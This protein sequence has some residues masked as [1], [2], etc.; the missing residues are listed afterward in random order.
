MKNSTARK[1]RQ[2][3]AGFL[4]VGVDPHKKKHAAAAMT[5]DAVIRCK[6][7]VV[8]SRR[9]YE[10]L[11]ERTRAQMLVT[12]SRGVIFA[13]E[14][15]SHFWRNLAYYLEAHGIPFRLI[16]PFTLK[17]RREGRDLNRV[18]NDFRDAQMA[19]ELLRTGDF[20]QTKLPQGVY[21]ELRAAYNAYRRLVKDRAR[22]LNLLKGLLDGVFPEFDQ[23]F[24]DP[25]GKTA[26]AVLSLCPVPGVIAGMREE[27]YV[28][29]VK[30]GHGG[31]RLKLRKLRALHQ[32]ACTS[33]GI[34]LGKQSISVELC[35]LA[36]RLRINAE[37]V[38]KMEG[39]LVSL[40][41]SIED[42]R[43]LLSVRGLSYITV[44][45]ILAELGPLRF[46]QNAKQVIKMA[47]S[48]P[49]ESESAGRRGSRTPMS[50]KGRPGL[51]WCIW[52]AAI[53]LL[54]HNTDFRSWAKT[55]R[56]RPVH[57]HPLKKMEVIGAAANR[58]LRLAYALVRKQTLYQ[59]PGLVTAV[60]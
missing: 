23:V 53:C 4:L 28:S 54:R 19:A 18:K 43:Y 33:I 44:A 57:A 13:I 35:L 5:Q 46:Y 21:A 45:G 39:L 10:E 15:G 27:E 16:N 24:R 41:D 40:V 31:P 2:I 49:I 8:N 32:A 3:P 60:A 6:F 12:G 29:M 34:P 14:T 22:W 48:N 30:S 9:G 38:H 58:L 52:T 7:K 47:G 59:M 51:R 42:S 17:R 36:E 11:V 50:K 20:T 56:E 1:L 55:R 37:Q 26:L 25:A